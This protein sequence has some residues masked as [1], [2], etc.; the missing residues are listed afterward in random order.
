MVSAQKHGVGPGPEAGGYLVDVDGP[1]PAGYPA[2][3]PQQ[4]AGQTANAKPSR[5]WEVVP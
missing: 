4:A 3:R 1:R 5:R 2:Y